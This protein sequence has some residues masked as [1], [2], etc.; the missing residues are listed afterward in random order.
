MEK[1]LWNDLP[2]VLKKLNE[3]YSDEITNVFL[4]DARLLNEL[5]HENVVE[6]LTFCDNS[7]AIIVELCEI[8]MKSFQ[9]DQSFHSLDK[10]LKYLANNKLLDFFPGN[11][12]NY[13]WYIE[14]HYLYSL[15]K[16]CSYRYQTRKYFT[17]Q[18][19]LLQREAEGP[20]AL[21]RKNSLI[22]KLGNIGEA[23]SKIIQTRVLTENTRTIGSVE[24]VQHLWH[25]KYQ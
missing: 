7:V 1:R 14:L 20:F 4:K 25:R 19:I 24:Q 23:R 6:L 18:F 16:Y 15:E 17:E 13:K 21:F 3:T 8:L 10:I 11:C 9:G 12:K 2:I 5:R 22:C